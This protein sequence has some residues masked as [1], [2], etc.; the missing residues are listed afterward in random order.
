MSEKA[1]TCTAN[2]NAVFKCATCDKKIERVLYSTGHDFGE[3]VKCK[4]CRKIKDGVASFVYTGDGRTYSPFDPFAY[5]SFGWYSTRATFFDNKKSFEVFLGGEAVKFSETLMVTVSLYNSAGEEI[6]Y[7]CEIQRF[8]VGNMGGER[9]TVNL[10]E[11]LVRN[12]TYY[13]EY[14]LVTV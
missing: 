6:G 2:G 1:A 10:S 13:I 11:T 5:T 8:Y 12:A 7:C 3:G 4:K 14:T 9:Y